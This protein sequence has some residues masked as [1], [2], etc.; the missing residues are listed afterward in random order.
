MEGR[1][2]TYKVCIGRD[3][4]LWAWREYNR[5]ILDRQQWHSNGRNDDLNYIKYIKK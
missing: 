4:D 5:N 3:D 2:R 1:R